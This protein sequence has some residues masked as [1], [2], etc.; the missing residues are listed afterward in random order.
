MLLA[1]F[2]HQRCTLKLKSS[3]DNHRIN[4]STFKTLWLSVCLFVRARALHKSELGC[5]TLDTLACHC[6][7]QTWNIVLNGFMCIC[8]LF[9]YPFPIS[10]SADCKPTVDLVVWCCCFYLVLFCSLWLIFFLSVLYATNF[11]CMTRVMTVYLFCLLLIVM[12]ADV[13]STPLTKRFLTFFHNS[14]KESTLCCGK[15]VIMRFLHEIARQ[16]V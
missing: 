13:Q 4:Y 15:S 6:W 7:T 1:S 11:P 16:S 2:F 5:G 9:C 10:L 3:I 8:I 12:S 14:L